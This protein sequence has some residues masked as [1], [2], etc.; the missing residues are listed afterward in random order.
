[1]ELFLVFGLGVAA[2]CVVTFWAFAARLIVVV[3]EDA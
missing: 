3:D 2:G 1:M